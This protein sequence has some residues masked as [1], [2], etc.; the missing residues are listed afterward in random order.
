M[1]H[2]AVCGRWPT[3][4]IAIH[5]GCPILRFFLAKGGRPRTLGWSISSIP[6]VMKFK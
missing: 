4:D 6:S 5:S 1:T 2:S 3:L